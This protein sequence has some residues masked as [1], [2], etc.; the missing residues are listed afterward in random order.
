MTRTA[1]LKK[2]EL[3][4]QEDITTER[5]A[6]YI[7]TEVRKLLEHLGNPSEF[8]ALDFY[9]WFALEHLTG[10]NWESQF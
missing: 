10:H 5:Q 8:Y 7:L 6:N 2:L 4:L 9:C 3:E 1:I